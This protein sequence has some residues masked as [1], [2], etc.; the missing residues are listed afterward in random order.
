MV[1]LLVL[2]VLEV[3]LVCGGGAYKV[4]RSGGRGGELFLASM[5]L[6]IIYIYIYIYIIALY[7]PFKGPYIAPSRA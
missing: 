4:I 5:V 1:V 3:V 6:Y 7:S 2:V